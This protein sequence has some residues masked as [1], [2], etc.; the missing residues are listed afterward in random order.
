MCCNDKQKK[1]EGLFIAFILILTLRNGKFGGRFL[2]SLTLRN[3]IGDE[4]IGS[5]NAS[6]LK[7][8][9]RAEDSSIE[10][11]A[12]SN[13]LPLTETLCSYNMKI[14]TCVTPELIGHW[15]FERFRNFTHA[16]CCDPNI[17]FPGDRHYC[18]VRNYSTRIRPSFLEGS[19]TGLAWMLGNGCEWKCRRRF[20]DEFVWKSP[21]LPEWNPSEFCQLLRSHRRIIMIGDSTMS[22]AATTLMNAVH[23]WCQT[24]LV[25][26]VVD[27]LIKEEFGALNRGPH[28]L[29]IVRNHSI[30]RDGDIVVLTVGAHIANKS[31]L[32]NVS[33]LVMQQIVAMKVER[34]S[35]IF[36]YKTQQP[37]GCTPRIANVSLSPLQ[38]GETFNFSGGVRFNHHFFYEYDKTVICHLQELGIPYLDM[39]MLFSRS[40]AHPTSKLATRLQDCLHFCSPGPLDMFAILFL[41]LLQSNFTVSQCVF[42]Y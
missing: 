32:Y 31:D 18:Q 19:Q 30:T 5:A 6:T 10:K 20:R 33:N 24:Q 9:T 36:V 22:Q 13:S 28:W 29:E 42:E 8:L 26:F 25:Y 16:H 39:R 23:G 14:K 15:Q 41:R 4:N 1:K 35:L 27:T 17:E 3:Y 37:G 21:N 7:T 40:D 2:G 11:N 34:P 38:A 12:A